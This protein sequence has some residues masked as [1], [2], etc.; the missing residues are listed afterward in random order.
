[1][2]AAT[3]DRACRHGLATALISDDVCKVSSRPP[4]AWTAAAAD[5][6][7]RCR[8]SRTVRGSMHDELI[9]D[10]RL[11]VR[12]DLTVNRVA[13]QISYLDECVCDKRTAL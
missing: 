11:P 8:E 4:A 1:M 7:G 13:N 6:V 5:V 9:I 2:P 3:S 12:S 10:P